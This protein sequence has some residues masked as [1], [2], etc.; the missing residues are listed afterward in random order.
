VTNLGKA[1]YWAR[2]KQHF[3]IADMIKRKDIIR[4]EYLAKNP[5]AAPA[6]AAAPAQDMSTESKIGVLSPV[7]LRKT[8]EAATP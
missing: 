3:D 6:P 5:Q 8:A 4:A 1:E 2:D 7:Q